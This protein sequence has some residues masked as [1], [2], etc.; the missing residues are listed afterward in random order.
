MSKYLLEDDFDFDFHLIG[1]STHAHDYRI[2][3]AINQLLDINLERQEEV[4]LTG[5]KGM[6]SKFSCFHYCSDDE[7]TEIRL[8]ANKDKKVNL[9]GDQKQADFL[10]QIYDSSFEEVKEIMLKLRTINVILMCFEINVSTL[11]SK[12]NLVF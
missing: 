10:L 4:E 5:K 7:E 6:Q 11:K 12:T 3:W 2:S 9:L 1:I 8:L